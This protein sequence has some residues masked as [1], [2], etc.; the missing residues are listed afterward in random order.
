M[1]PDNEELDGRAEGET[2][3]EDEQD[4]VAIGGNSEAEEGE[5][6]VEEEGGEQPVQGGGGAAEQEGGRA[7]G[8][9]GGEGERAVPVPLEPLAAEIKL[10][11]VLLTCRRLRAADHGD[12]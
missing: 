9:A 5:R 10:S 2:G 1:D 4:R 11:S 7:E 8:G 12:Q 6:G 3:P